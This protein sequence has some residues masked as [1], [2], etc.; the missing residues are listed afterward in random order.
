MSHFEQKYCKINF[1][2]L[3]QISQ[4]VVWRAVVSRSSGFGGPG[5]KLLKSSRQ[6]VRLLGLGV[7]TDPLESMRLLDI[8]EVKSAGHR[9]GLESRVAERVA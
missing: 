5:R 1:V 2:H 3:R 8:E 7:V 9:D 6:E 4:A